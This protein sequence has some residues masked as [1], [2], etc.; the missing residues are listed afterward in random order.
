MIGSGYPRK[1]RAPRVFIFPLIKALNGFKRFPVQSSRQ[2]SLRA[3]QFFADPCHPSRPNI[4]AERQAQLGTII[5]STR[6]VAS[7][8]KTRSVPK[9][10]CLLS[11]KAEN[12]RQVLGQ[13]VPLAGTY[14]GLKN[15]AVI[16]PG[17]ESRPKGKSRYGKHTVMI[18]KMKRNNK[19]KV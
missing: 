19:E 13:S 8:H 7:F 1:N 16:N 15:I 2:S 3:Q 10:N 12:R 18:K 6:P 4:P 17:R 14:S 9:S 5:N 11:N